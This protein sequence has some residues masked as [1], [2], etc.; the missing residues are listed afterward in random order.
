LW[1]ACT[2]VFYTSEDFVVSYAFV[3]RASPR[4]SLSMLSDRSGSVRSI[5]GLAGKAGP[6]GLDGPRRNTEFASRLLDGAP[7]NVARVVE[8]GNPARRSCEI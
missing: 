7:V 1:L 5:D 8:P 2:A 6:D 3:P 4:R